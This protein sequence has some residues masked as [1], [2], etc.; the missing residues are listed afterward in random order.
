MEKPLRKDNDAPLRGVRANIVQ[1]IRAHR[2][3]DLQD[4]AAVL[5]QHF[6]YANLAHALTKQDVLDLIEYANGPVTSVWG[7]IRAKNGHP[8]PFNLKYLEIWF[9]V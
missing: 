3:Q 2:V 9:M 4:A 5:G 1:S 6:L 7:S 8:A